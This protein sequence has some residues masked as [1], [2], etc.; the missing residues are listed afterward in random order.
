M[1]L[2][3]GLLPVFRE[4]GQMPTGPLICEPSLVAPF[5]AAWVPGKVL[6][7]HSL[8]VSRVQGKV[9]QVELKDELFCA[10]WQALG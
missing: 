5:G 1:L 6:R 10:W 3:P 2:S 7:A 4:R 9:G 8:V